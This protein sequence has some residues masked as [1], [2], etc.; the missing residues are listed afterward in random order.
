MRVIIAG[1]GIGGVCTALAL[2]RHGIDY[3]I[4]EQAAALT[5]VG[6]GV[7]L[8]PNGVRVLDALGIGGK[9]PAF[10]VEPMA[11]RFQDWRTGELLLTLPLMPQVRETFGQPYY[12]AHRADLLAA[13]VTELAG[14]RLH[15][16]A[17]VASVAQDSAA[18]TA[19]LT[20]GTRMT[21]DVLIG[22]D[23]IHSAVRARMFAPD[24]PRFAGYAAWRGMVPAKE[25]A[26]LGIERNAYVW[27]GPGRSVVVY[28]ISGGRTVNWIAIGLS[29]GALSESWSARGTTADALQEVA[30]W[31]EQVRGLV[32]LTPAPL[33]TRLYDREPMVTWI[34]GRAALLGDAAHAMLPYHA[35]GAVQSIEDSWVLAGCLAQ[36]VQ[37]KGEHAITM[38]LQRYESL[39]R[40]RTAQVQQQ[41]RAAQGSYHL[42]DAAEIAQRN[43]RYR[44]TQAEGTGAGFSKGQ[45]WLY[46]YDAEKA[47]RGADADWQKS[48]W[49]GRG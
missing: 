24:R 31:H 28:Y 37:E 1:G 36:A 33:I 49:S 43:A 4:L 34:N 13:L 25:V 3:C 39:R 6:A 32:A 44:R 35:Q 46:A 2:R 15:L 45:T 7:Q 5:E 30:G 29:P 38:A 19:M 23:G 20:D 40:E 17:K 41:S 16:N 21:G 10:C 12:H 14:D 9:L 18:V 27:L 11:H 8:S 47:V 26:H 22:A 48:R 42:S